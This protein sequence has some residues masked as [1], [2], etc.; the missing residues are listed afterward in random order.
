MKTFLFFIIAGLLA[1]ASCTSEKYQ[2]KQVT[3]PNGYSYEMVTNDPSGL[4]I[5][6][7]DNGL[8]VYLA[9]NKI[10]PRIM[11]MIGIRAGSNNDPLETTGLAHYFE[12]QMF[13]VVCKYLW[14]RRLGEGETSTGFHLCPF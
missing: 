2:I 13:K 14:Y 3:D 9:V 12:H 10:E 11:T 1:M 6:T 4:R 5:Y 8:K 7:L